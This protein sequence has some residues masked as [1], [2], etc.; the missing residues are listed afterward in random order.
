MIVDDAFI[1]KIRSASKKEVMAMLE[2]VPAE[3]LE[4]IVNLS[5]KLRD[6]ME[7]SPIDFFHPHEAQ[8]PFLDSVKRNAWLFGGN[9]SGKTV[10]GAIRTISFLLGRPVGGMVEFAPKGAPNHGW[11]AGPMI[12]HTREVML[13]EIMKWIP[14]HEVQDYKV[15]EKKL[16]MKN[17]STLVL[18]SYDSEVEKWQGKP[19]DFLWFDEQPGHPHYIEGMSRVN[20]RN[21][22]IYC[23]MTPAYANSSW[24]YDEIY[25]KSEED[26]DLG[27]Y[28]ADLSDNIFLSREAH[29][30]QMKAYVGTVEEAARIHGEFVT[31]S[32]IIHPYFKMD[33]HVINPV[34]LDS[35]FKYV[36]VIDLHTRAPKTCCWYAYKEQ[37]FPMVYQI[38]ELMIAGTSIADFAAA[39]RIKDAGLP[40]EYTIVDTPESQDATTYGTNMV[41]ELRRNGIFCT[42]TYDS[43]HLR[44]FEMGVHRANDYFMHD[45]PA[46]CIFDKCRTTIRQ[47]R[48]YIWDNWKG[49]SSWDKNPKEKPKAKEDHAVRNLHYFLLTMPSIN[50]IGDKQRRDN[51]RAS[52]RRRDN[53]RN[54]TKGLVKHG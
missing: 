24:S 20:R 11:I 8:R 45:P 5:G 15:G 36:R 9:A 31:L 34:P 22:Y 1:E 52:S 51:S 44:N 12:E 33:K 7:Q 40:I 14:R 32:G 28:K 38:E 54:Y 46:I 35:S 17:G 42:T 6:S 49:T 39:I 18:K 4:K 10:V 26:D 47:I 43:A 23:T 30:R 27:V 21:G 19:L 2:G 50:E 29:A 13:E 53:F 3:E 48:N 16:Y 37:P 25:L 41:M